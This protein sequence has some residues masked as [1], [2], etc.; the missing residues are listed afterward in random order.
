MRMCTL[1]EVQNGKHISHSDECGLS[2]EYVWT[3]SKCLGSDNAECNS[4]G[5]GGE[6]YYVSTINRPN[7]PLG[8]GK[9]SSE[10]A[11]MEHCSYRHS[12]FLFVYFSFNVFG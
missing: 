11:R 3:N 2:S 12:D 4:V 5:A 10:G 7:S 6:A 8:Q 1:F 9:Y